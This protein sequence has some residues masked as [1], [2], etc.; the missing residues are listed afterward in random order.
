MKLRTKC[1]YSARQVANLLLIA[2]VFAL[3]HAAEAQQ[4]VK[5]PHIAFLGGSSMSAYSSFV[6]VLQKGLRELGYIEG[7]T[8]RIEYSYAEGK[9]DRLPGLAAE[10]AQLGVDL[11]VVSGARATSEM[12]N[13]TRI[14][15]IVM[16]TI[17]DPVAM[18]I[19]NSLA[20][21]GGNITGLTNLAPELSGK[22]LEL[23]KEAL[24]KLSQVAVLWPP[25][26]AG[27]V[28]TFKE[29][30]VAAKSL[31]IQLQSVELQNSDDF[32]SAFRTAITG[33]AGALLVLQSAL[34]NANR[35]TIA[36]LSLQNRFPAMYTQ[37]EY[38]DAGGLM[39]YGVDT[40]DLYRR[41]A[42][43]VDKILKGAKPANLPVEQPTKFEFVINLKTAKQIGLTIP[44][45]VLA[46]ADRVIR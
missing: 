37:D 45:N 36:D 35:K 46:R 1:K 34:T 16:T 28:V 2:V 31:G 30:Q 10:L 23:L 25:N 14:I 42:I 3:V 15:P 6:E 9:L 21:P 32:A 27:A 19:V 5:V 41:A 4:P 13:A 18:G 22:R 29:T 7:K 44:P 39:S 20:R 38:V 33:R 26:A 11:I 43:Y 12:K 17:E 24:P 8:I 40:G